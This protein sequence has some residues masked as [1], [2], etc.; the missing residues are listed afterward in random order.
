MLIDD[1]YDASLNMLVVCMSPALPDALSRVQ[2]PLKKFFL[3]DSS[4]SCFLSV[5]FF[6]VFRS[7]RTACTGFAAWSRLLRRRGVPF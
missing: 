5:L 2:I 7:S 3:L 1:P 4:S 6:F